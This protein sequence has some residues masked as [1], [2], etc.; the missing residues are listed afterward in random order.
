MK[1]AALSLTCFDILSCN[2]K[3]DFVFFFLNAFL[4]EKYYL[5]KAFLNVND[6]CIMHHLRCS[7]IFIIGR[8][9]I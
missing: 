4:L 2:F 3:F 7:G 8:M 6:G 1:F 5:R 9:L